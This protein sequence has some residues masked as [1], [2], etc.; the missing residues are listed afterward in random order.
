M[1]NKNNALLNR[2]KH[3]QRHQLS[4]LA[5]LQNNIRMTTHKFQVTTKIFRL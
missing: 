4:I 1:D 5:I 3:Q 2:E